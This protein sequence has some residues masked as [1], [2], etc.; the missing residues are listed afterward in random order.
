MVATIACPV[1]Q[2]AWSVNVLSGQE[3]GSGEDVPSRPQAW[4]PGRKPRAVMMDAADNRVNFILSTG[5]QRGCK[6]GVPSLALLYP[7]P[8]K[9]IPLND[10]KRVGLSDSNKGL[11][12]TP[13]SN[14]RRRSGD[15]RVPSRP[16]LPALHIRDERRCA[17]MVDPRAKAFNQ[18]ERA[19]GKL[20]SY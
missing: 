2:S 19:R 15:N 14:R 3:G 11:D 9:N 13:S 4:V 18:H 1:G 20:S 5:G 12:D 6:R 8:A 16:R 7:T 17:L 10:G